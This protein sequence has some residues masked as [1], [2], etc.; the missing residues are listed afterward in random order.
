[1]RIGLIGCGN[2]GVNAHIPAVAANEG[3]TIVAA[4]DPTPERLH[5][6]AEA[7]TAVAEPAAT[8]Q[9]VEDG[10]PTAAEP[11]AAEPTAEDLRRA[12]ANASSLLPSP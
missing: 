5:A 4:A 6:A 2:I 8:E 11:T 12:A 7:P 1:M 9:T 3:M 10:E